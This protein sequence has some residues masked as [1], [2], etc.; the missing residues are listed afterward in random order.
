MVTEFRLV[1]NGIEDLTWAARVHGCERF[2]SLRGQELRGLVRA[3]GSAAG[4]AL[5]WS[6]DWHP[7]PAPYWIVAFL[8][9]GQYEIGLPG[10]RD[11]LD[12]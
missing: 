10:Y 12:V 7:L 3:S 5:P 9:S 2:E 4:R 11:S 8:P 6:G 1:P